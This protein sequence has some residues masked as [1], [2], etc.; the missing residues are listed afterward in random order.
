MGILSLIYY[1]GLKIHRWWSS[2]SA[3]PGILPTVVVGNLCTGGSGKSPMIAHLAENLLR[4]GIKPAILS[5]GYGRKTKGLHV[6]SPEDSPEAAGDEPLLLKNMFPDIPVIC[7]EDRHKGLQYLNSLPE[8]PDLVLLDDGFQH[9]RLIPDFSLVL[10]S[11]EDLRE[12]PRLLPEGKFREPF[13][14]LRRANA[15]VITKVPDEEELD[16][17][18]LRKQLN[19]SAQIPLGYARLRHQLPADFTAK[20]AV[21]ITGIARPEALVNFLKQQG[22]SLIHLAFKDH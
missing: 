15:V 19:L 2:L 13:S 18:V 3:K 4:K 14:A 1:T 16:L 12:K 9:R 8:P 6:V 5:R 7:C 17:Q 20:K 11:R 22:I 10:I 21:L